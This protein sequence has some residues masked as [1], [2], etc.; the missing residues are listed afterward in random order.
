MVQRR[1]Q[2]V[3]AVVQVPMVVAIESAVVP[4]LVMPT[5]IF[6]ICRMSSSGQWLDHPAITAVGSAVV[7]ITMAIVRWH[8]T[9]TT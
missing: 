8:L 9:L 4:V 5:P 7:D 6:A 1:L 3:A 2:V